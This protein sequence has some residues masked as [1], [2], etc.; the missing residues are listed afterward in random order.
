MNTYNDN[1]L[2]EKSRSVFYKA[3]DKI[4]KALTDTSATNERSLSS[5]MLHALAACADAAACGFKA[6]EEGD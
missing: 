6:D 1:L 4:E 5:E 2:D 3:M